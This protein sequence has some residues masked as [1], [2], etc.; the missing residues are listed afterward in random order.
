MQTYLKYALNIKGNLVHIDNVPNG[1]DCGCVCPACKKP[2]QARNAG[3]IREHHF[4]HQVGVD[5]PTAYETSLHLLAKEKIQKAFY[6]QQAFMIDFEYRSFCI[7]EHTCKFE[8]Y[9]DCKT[10]KRSRYNLKEY[11][12]S[13]EQ[14]VQYDDIIRRSDL[15]IW[16]SK[17]PKKEPIYIE[18]FVTHKSDAEKLHS[19]KKIIEVKIESEA[20]IDNIV[21]NGFVENYTIESYYYNETIQSNKVLFCGFKSEDYENTSIN[22]EI[23]FSRYILYKSGKAQCYQDSCNCKR[24]KKIYKNSLCEILFHTSVGFRIHD[25]AKWLGFQK[26]GIYNC[27]LC[28]NY[29]TRYSGLEELCRLYKYLGI[30]RSED[31]D[32]ARARSCKYFVLN[33]EEKNKC[34]KEIQENKTY[35]ITELENLI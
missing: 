27:L 19:G 25:I 18:I 2:L 23:E 31:H 17:S 21:L 13:C 33:V 29:V 9:G 16:S 3:L 32:T 14:E 6:E 11:Y 15:K 1:N 34:L 26:F 10:I 28:K 12:D 35:S 20:D 5:C 22:Q 24:I 4:A 30:D 8:R 7:N